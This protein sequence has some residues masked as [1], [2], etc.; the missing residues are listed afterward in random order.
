MIPLLFSFKIFHFDSKNKLILIQ[1]RFDSS[2]Y[3]QKFQMEELKN[4][5][6]ILFL[7]NKKQ[8]EDSIFEGLLN[9]KQTEDLLKNY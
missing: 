8:T 2:A 9:K 5:S 4:A 6:K 3:F 1:N 7:K